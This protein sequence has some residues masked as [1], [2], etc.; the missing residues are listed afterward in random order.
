MPH[1]EGGNPGASSCNLSGNRAAGSMHMGTVRKTL[2]WL[3]GIVLALN[4]AA[5]LFVTFFDWNRARPWVDGKVSA[6]IGRPFAINGDLSVHWARNPD[7]GGISA[8]VPWPRFIARNVS[9]AN[10]AW[11]KAKQFATLEQIQFSLAPLAL[12]GHT[13]DI[14][15]LKL[16]RPDVD[17]ERDASGRA[18][19]NFALDRKST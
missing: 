11:A 14:S 3:V 18:N 17:L 1:A 5:I 8:W 6:A 2:I 13:L 15:T 4:V 12:L 7:A 19:W 9:V 16:T 10:P